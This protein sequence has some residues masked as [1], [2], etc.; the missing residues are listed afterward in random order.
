M[1]HCT[2]RRHMGKQVT[3]RQGDV[4]TWRTCFWRGAAITPGSSSLGAPG[5]HINVIHM[6]QWVSASSST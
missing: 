2:N 4:T 6:R 5:V 1:L 3:N